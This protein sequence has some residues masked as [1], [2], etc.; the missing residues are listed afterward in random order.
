MLEKHLLITNSKTFSVRDKWTQYDIDI[1]IEKLQ[2]SRRFT[3]F[4]FVTTVKGMKVAL[5]YFGYKSFF[6]EI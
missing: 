4:L 6:I 1:E 5:N 3:I 2:N